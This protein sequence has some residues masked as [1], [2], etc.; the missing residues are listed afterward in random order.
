MDATERE[1]RLA[2]TAPRGVLA[3]L[4][5]ARQGERFARLKAA[6][7]STED[8]EKTF[9]VLL[10]TLETVEQLVRSLRSF[11]V[12]PLGDLRLRH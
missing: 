12:R 2:Q 4:I 6:G 9:G 1:G 11:S 7:C 8:D 5:V 10:S 3:R